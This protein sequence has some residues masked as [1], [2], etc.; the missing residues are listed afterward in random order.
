MKKKQN[1]L[2]LHSLHIP[3]LDLIPSLVHLH[4]EGYSYHTDH[5]LQFIYNEGFQSD[6]IQDCVVVVHV[7]IVPVSGRKRNTRVYLF[8]YDIMYKMIYFHRT[9]SL[10]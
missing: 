1:S 10:H 5:F 8:P 3:T 4:G 7:K 6:F 2:C 9:D